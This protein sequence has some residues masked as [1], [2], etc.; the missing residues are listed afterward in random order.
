[1][2]L[3]QHYLDD[4][5]AE[6]ESNH[7]DFKYHV[8]DSKKIAKT[9]VAFA[10]TQG[11]KL[12]LGVKD[13]GKII[14]VESDEERYMIETASSMFCNPPVYY[15]IEEWVYEDK[16]VI[17]VDIP[18]SQEKPHYVKNEEGKWRVYIR[19]ND[20]NKFANRVVVEF[21]KRQQSS[22]NTF[23]KYTKNENVLLDFLNDNQEITFKQFMKIAKLKPRKAENILI[24]LA[25]I[26]V[27]E[28]KHN[29][30]H[31]YYTLKQEK[32]NGTDGLF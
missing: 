3:K 27:L 22:F 12:L 8:G 30:K 29:E 13:N 18:V 6:G 2:Q 11:G 5:I 7:L 16:T 28:I 31:F 14:G 4:L 25:S 32:Q 9:L 19:V 17:E 23:I 26:G 15:S 10:N 1:M 20:K 24:N 21:L